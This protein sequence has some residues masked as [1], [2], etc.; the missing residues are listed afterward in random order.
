[1]SSSKDDGSVDLDIRRRSNVTSSTGYGTG[2]DSFD[3]NNEFGDL[4][5]DDKQLSHINE[6]SEKKGYDSYKDSGMENSKNETEVKPENSVVN[7][8]SSFELDLQD[9]PSII[10]SHNEH[11]IDDN[12]DSETEVKPDNLQF[13]KERFVNEILG[14]SSTYISAG[15]SRSSSVELDHAVLT[16]LP[17]IDGDTEVLNLKAILEQVREPHKV[18]KTSEV[19]DL[20]ALKCLP[21]LPAPHT[22]LPN[23]SYIMVDQN[24][25]DDEGACVYHFDSYLETSTIHDQFCQAQLD[26]CASNYASTSYSSTSDGYSRN[27]LTQEAVQSQLKIYRSSMLYERVTKDLQE[28]HLPVCCYF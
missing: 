3:D 17:S 11:S 14:T 20:I 6:V 24:S 8:S 1:M 13:W 26:N 10:P 4:Q 25:S 15:I 21:E 7:S 23:L 16:N 5:N 28:N 9:L 19:H 18:E 27:D 2:G 22:E 12:T